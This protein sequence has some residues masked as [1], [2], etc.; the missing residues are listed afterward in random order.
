MYTTVNDASYV[1]E[2]QAN[3]YAAIG[4]LSADN[5]GILSAF[6]TYP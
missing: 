1:A 5:D 6:R 2:L 4:N 3:A